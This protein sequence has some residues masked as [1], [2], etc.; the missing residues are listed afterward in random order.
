MQRLIL[1]GPSGLLPV[2]LGA[3]LF[4][5]LAGRGQAQNDAGPATVEFSDARYTVTENSRSAIITIK[6]TGATNSAI[7]VRFTSS[8]DTAR[9]PQDY[10]ATN[11]VINLAPGV[12]E[13]KVRVPLVD[14]EVTQSSLT[15]DLSL[16]EP[17]GGA[18]LGVQSTAVLEILDND[19]V[20]SAWISFG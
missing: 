20:R 5:L 19:A 1:N 7:S 2:L 4:V 11:M 6:R 18:A 14:D 15:V 12:I 9:S 3:V 13:S 17:S 8:D 10:L 16:S